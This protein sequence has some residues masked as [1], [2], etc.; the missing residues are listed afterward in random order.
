MGDNEITYQTD[1]I[2]KQTKETTDS[3]NTYQAK[4]TYQM[5][6]YSAIKYAN[7]LLLLVYV[8]LF[9]VIHALFLQQYLIG[10]NRNEIQDI[11]WLIFFFLYPY[12]IYNLEKAIYFC[13]TYVLSLIYGQSYVYQFDQLLLFT[14]YYQ[15]PKPTN[16]S[17]LSA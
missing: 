9:C 13:I 15:A 10:V 11:I 6:M 1:S 16:L 12:L 7:E 8:V 17:A 3:T 2:N 5:E 4:T 14:D